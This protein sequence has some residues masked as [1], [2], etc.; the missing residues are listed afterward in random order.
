[1]D[2]RDRIVTA[3]RARAEDGD[4]VNLGHRHADARREPHPAGVQIT[5]HSENGLLGIGRFPP[6]TRSIPISSTPERDR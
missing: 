4:Y 1:M 3:H 2:I 5:L 6:T